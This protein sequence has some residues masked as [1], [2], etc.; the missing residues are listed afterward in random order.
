LTDDD[1]AY[2]IDFG[3]ARASGDTALTSVNTTL[4]TW[5]Y[6][7]PERFTT[8]DIQPSSD[9][10]ALACVLYQCLTGKLPYP[11]DALEQIAVGHMS[12]TPPRPSEHQPGVPAAMDDV[13]AAG[14]AKQPSDRYPSTIELAAAARRAIAGPTGASPPPPPVEPVAATSAWPASSASNV[15]QAWA[16][17]G[18]SPAPPTHFGVPPQP[19][20][21]RRRRPAV[22]IGAL[23]AVA[24]LIAG[25]AFAVVR[26]S[27]DDKPTTTEPSRAAAP[28]TAGPKPNT[29]PFTGVY[30][31]D[32]GRVTGLDGGPA[33][34]TV[35]SVGTYGVSSVCTPT[36]CVATATKMKGEDTLAP[37][38][39]FDEVG[40]RWLSV[41]VAPGECRGAP[42]DTWQAFRLQPRP[43]G[44]LTGDYTRMTSNLC[45]ERRSVTLTRTG[46]VDVNADFFSVADPAALPPRVVSPAEALRGRYHISRTFSPPRMRP[47]EADSPVTTDCLRTG[48]RCMSY[49]VVRSGDIAMVY[50]GGSWKS[51]DRAEG[52]CPNGDL[53]TLTADAQYLLPEPPQDPIQSLR[54]HGTWVQTASCGANLQYDEI[55]TRTG[56]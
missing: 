29:G 47:M 17:V 28:S 11:G 49:F 53:A 25:G 50:D 18:P 37:T 33:P 2:L 55:F 41:T 48:E 26:F 7:A 10:Y 42:T 56:D 6:M 43:D 9:V 21:N 24:L 35:P 31:A 16:S 44:T 27:G 46:D 45:A 20:A 15:T 8:A 22:L 38:I 13:I 52:P 54:G 3:I 32:F 36:G 23:A 14:L 51:S 40:E 12:A 19:V 39:V 5:A 34:N 30:R 4:G 1:F